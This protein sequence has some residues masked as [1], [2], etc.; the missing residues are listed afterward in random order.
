MFNFGKKKE[1]DLPKNAT[2]L[3]EE[4]KSLREENRK[5]KKEIE[6]IKEREKYFFQNVGVV[7]F[8]PFTQEGGN[9]SFSIAL[10]NGEQKGFVITSLYTKEGNRV[11]GKPISEG[12]SKYSLSEE[13]KEAIKK[14]LK[15]E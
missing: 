13:E 4:L 6:D 2:E 11:Y 3:L 14:A 7:R 15:R 10:L 12:E 9:Q 5:I 1:E 8:N